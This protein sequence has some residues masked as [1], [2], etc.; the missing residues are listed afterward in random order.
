LRVFACGGS[1]RRDTVRSGLERLAPDDGD[2][3]LVHDAARPGLT[4]PMLD[5]LIDACLVDEVGGLLALP[6]ADTLKSADGHDRV[7]RTVPR[8]RLFAAQTPQMFRHP[9]LAHALER[10]P[11][12]TDEASAVEALGLHP[13][14]VRGA[15]R[16]F[17]LT[18]PEDFGLMEAILSKENP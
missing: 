1:T 13:K 4:V 8:D 14:L 5:R 15:Q 7:E 9:M 18:W 10:A 6:V 2:W 16:N 3:I 11:L 12:A 17:K